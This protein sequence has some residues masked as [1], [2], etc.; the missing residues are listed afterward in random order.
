MPHPRNGPRC[1]CV[2]GHAVRSRLDLGGVVVFVAK[3]ERT[4]RTVAEPP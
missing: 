1:F 2:T 3:K 4:A